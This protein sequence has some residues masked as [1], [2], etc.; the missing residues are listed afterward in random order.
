[1]PARG[2]GC[3]AAWL[4]TRLLPP[5]SAS[6]LCPSLGCRGKGRPAGPAP[7]SLALDQSHPRSAWGPACSS[8]GSE[9]TLC[10]PPVLRDL[11]FSLPW[12]VC[13]DFISF[14]SF[15]VAL[16]AGPSRSCPCRRRC[17]WRIC[18]VLELP[19]LLFSLCPE[20]VR[21]PLLPAAA[22][23]LAGACLPSCPVWERSADAPRGCLCARAAG[24][25]RHL[26][27]AESQVPPRLLGLGAV[28]E[29][30]FCCCGV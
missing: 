18:D 15:S 29:R 20:L 27:R 19:R 26:H 9:P 5:L 24:V 8:F 16:G 10:H 7:V 6:G 25:C 30:S 3:P 4:G 14:L 11:S 13:A 17:N 12:R 22:S 1:M 2:P 28:W 21:E 23:V